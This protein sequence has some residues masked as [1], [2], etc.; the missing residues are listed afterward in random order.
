VRVET[1]ED[2]LSSVQAWAED[3][4]ADLPTCEEDA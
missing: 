1:F 4:D 2:A 3:P